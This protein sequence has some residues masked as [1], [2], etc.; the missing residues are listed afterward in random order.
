MKNRRRTNQKRNDM[1]PKG[2]KGNGGDI[3]NMVKWAAVY[4]ALEKQIEKQTK[5]DSWQNDITGSNI[6]GRDKMAG[7]FFSPAPYWTGTV[8]DQMYRSDPIIQKI[9]E[10]FPR[11]ALRKG[12]EI[13]CDDNKV[14]QDVMHELNFFDI[15]YEGAM[16]ARLYGGAAIMLGI[17]DGRGSSEPVDK[18]NIQRIDYVHVYDR[19][20]AFC[21]DGIFEDDLL[22]PNYGY[23]V[24]YNITDPT[25]AV[26][27]RVHSDRVIRVNG[28]LPVPRQRR[29]NNAW[30]ES[31][32]TSCYQYIRNYCGTINSVATI[33]GD[34]VKTVIKIPNLSMQLA[35]NPQH[36]A[37]KLSVM[38]LS[39][40]NNNMIAIDCEEEME[41]FSVSMA[42]YPELFDRIALGLAAVV[43]IPAGMLFGIEPNGLNASGEY[44]TRNM[45][46]AISAYQ[47]TK[48]EHPIR[49]M[50]EYIM[51]A[52]EY[53][54]GAIPP[55]WS[56]QFAPLEQMS[57]L[58]QA[59]LRRDVAEADRIY[60]E[61][62]VLTPSEVAMSRFGGDA[63]S[64][65]TTIDP[66]LHQD[67]QFAHEIAHE[68]MLEQSPP[69]EQAGADVPAEE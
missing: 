68:Q 66:A 18:N 17:A 57:E 58:D 10:L 21:A 61:Q 43:Q 47:K 39:S 50:A 40:S 54:F 46:D 4:N 11:E 19:F 13:S 44:S 32:I 25:T 69:T 20:N 29:M 60:I 35:S 55:R 16:W 41:R 53:Q 22:S 3:A 51:L 62:S 27:Y 36:V 14:I 34:M 64:I 45:Y 9:I 30:G 37:A 24:T 52:Q 48:L 67:K 28:I 42:G 26:T 31:I 6:Y 5:N 1:K 33:F 12:F 15:L 2:F 63:Y 38:A 7:T 59:K 8:F 23:P 65:E 49:K 56:V